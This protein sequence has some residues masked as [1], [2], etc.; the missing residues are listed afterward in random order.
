MLS[1]SLAE[2]CF[3]F[4]LEWELP[5]V[6]DE[7]KKRNLEP[8]FPVVIF[9][10]SSGP[11][12]LVQCLKSVDWILSQVIFPPAFYEPGFWEAEC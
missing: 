8:W 4:F 5:V 7:M 3:F 6:F 1:F 10:L 12:E 9:H 11:M 2:L